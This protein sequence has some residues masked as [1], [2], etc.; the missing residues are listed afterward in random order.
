MEIDKQKCI[1]NA[2]AIFTYCLCVILFFILNNNIISG[3]ITDF[4]LK[5]LELDNNIKVAIEVDIALFFTLA[6]IIFHIYIYQQYFAEYL[7][8]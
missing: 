7:R 3:H 1:I 6:V 8:K 5:I 4:I 2:K